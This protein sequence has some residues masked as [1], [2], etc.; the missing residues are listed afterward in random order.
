MDLIALL[1]HFQMELSALGRRML[2][3]LSM[4]AVRDISISVKIEAM[5]IKFNCLNFMNNQK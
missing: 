3:G 2:K 5:N 4:R 1:A